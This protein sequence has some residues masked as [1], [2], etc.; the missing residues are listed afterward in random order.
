M[1]Y[2]DVLGI[3]AGGAAVAGGTAAGSGALPLTG[4]G[5]TFA[6]VTVTLSWIIA[7]ALLRMDARRGQ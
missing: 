7:F 5:I 4:L 1:E 2:G 3:T 6:G